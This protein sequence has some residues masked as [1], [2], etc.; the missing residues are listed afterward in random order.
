M[1]IEAL[2]YLLLVT[3][4]LAG[5]A[6]TPATPAFVSLI[7]TPMTSV[8]PLPSQPDAVATPTPFHRSSP[9]PISPT[10]PSQPGRPPS[11]PIPGTEPAVVRAVADL[12]AR[13]EVAKEEITVLS[14]T[15]TELPIQDLGCPPEGKEPPIT[16]PGIVMG[17][18]IVLAVGSDEY[19]YHARS[20]QVVFCGRR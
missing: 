6:R 10:V 8:T 14:V 18:E 1:R 15:M 5:C 2:I 11:T 16:L 7:S 17:Q 20:R 3:A 4:L 19:I 12:A 13:L 9:D